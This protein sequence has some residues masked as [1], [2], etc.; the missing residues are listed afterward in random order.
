MTNWIDS[1]LSYCAN[2]RLKR[3]V[4]CYKIVIEWK[5]KI[6]RKDNTGVSFISIIIHSYGP[7]EVLTS[8]SAFIEVKLILY[9]YWFIF[10]ELDV[11]EQKLDE[12][13][14]NWTHYGRW[15]TKVSTFERW[16]TSN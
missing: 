16:G 13:D 9:V 10:Y 2:L 8:E 1:F 15:E 11:D 3:R 12:S 14:L 7:F 6:I 4:T 5:R